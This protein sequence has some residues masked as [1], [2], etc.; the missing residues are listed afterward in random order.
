M[1]EPLI[2]QERDLGAWWDA[3][4]AGGRRIVA[5]RRD[6][7]TV[8]FGEVASPME[9]AADVVQTT[10]SAKEWAFP[11]CEALLR[12]RS[13]GRDVA[14]ED[15]VAA[16]PPT[17][18]FGLRPCDARAF[19]ALEA[20]FNWDTADAPF[21]RRRR[22]LALVAV[23]CSRA[24]ADCFCTSTGGGPGDPAGSDV[25]LAPLGDGRFLV[26]A[27][28]R[29]GLD[30]LEAAPSLFAPAGGETITPKLAD[31]PRRFDLAVVSRRLGGAFADDGPWKEMSLRCLGCGACAFVCPACACFDIQDEPGRD[32]GVRLRCWDSCGFSQFTL[33][34]SGHNPREEQYQ[35]W[36]Q[37]V[38]HKFSYMPERLGVAGC[39]GCGRCARACPA[40]MGLPESLAA[41]AE[42]RG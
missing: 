6:G 1:S 37:R 12:Y 16:P 31:V 35:R 32:G 7:A 39:T 42:E 11:R 36:R 20:V 26:D 14:V 21:H 34:T 29:A 13:E 18:L 19:G 40:D 4:R 3:L 9:W 38:M 17:V 23:G 2:L 24:D 22:A 41:L 27:R 30:L 8:A 10:L 25:L 28:T 33:H 15:P 5:P